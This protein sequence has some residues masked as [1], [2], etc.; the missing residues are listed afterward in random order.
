MENVKQLMQIDTDIFGKQQTVG[1]SR[2]WQEFWWNFLVNI[3]DGPQKYFLLDLASTTEPDIIVKVFRNLE[4]WDRLKF[5]SSSC[6]ELFHLHNSLPKFCDNIWLNP[7]KAA[8]RNFELAREY[9]NIKLKFNSSQSR[10]KEILTP[11]VPAMKA[12]Q[13]QYRE[14]DDDQKNPNHHV[15]TVIA[16]IVETLPIMGNLTWLEITSQGWQFQQWQSSWC[17][18]N[19]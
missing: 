18:W 7:G 19:I 15:N 13:L 12:L 3:S 1:S 11:F 6:Q 4:M 14:K 8:S 9:Q 10:L 2:T 5:A 16:C 17:T